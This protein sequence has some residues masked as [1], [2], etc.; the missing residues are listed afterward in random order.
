MVGD[1]AEQASARGVAWFWSGILRTAASLLWCG[2]AENPVRV[3]GAALIGLATDIVAS[4]LLAGLSGV[5]FFV[6]ARNGHPAQSSSGWLMIWLGAMTLVISVFIGRLLARLAPGGE[7]SACL[8]YGII[9]SLFSLVMVF[10]SP[11]GLGLTALLTVFFSDVVQ[12]TPVLAGAIWG[13]HR[14][15]S[16]SR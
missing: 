16:V 12:R 9:G 2:F 11:E 14:K 1:F 7:L 4:L 15:Q 8:A 6:V 10:V 5:V 3:M 13:R